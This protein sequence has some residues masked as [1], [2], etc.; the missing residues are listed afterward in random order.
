MDNVIFY[1]FNPKEFPFDKDCARSIFIRLQGAYR[2]AY[3]AG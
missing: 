1:A 2:A 3:S